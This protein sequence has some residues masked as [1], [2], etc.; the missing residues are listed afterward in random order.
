MEAAGYPWWRQRIAKLTDIFHI[1]RIDHV[2]GFYRIYS[3]P[4]Q[5]QRNAE[6]LPLSEEEAAELTGGLLPEWAPRPDDTP[7]NKAA[8]RAD[9]DARLRMAIEA[10]GS[11]AVVGEDLGSVPDYVRPH[12][13]SLDVAGFRIPHW[14]SDDEGHVIPPGDLPECS[15]VTYSTHDHDSIPALWANFHRLAADPDA[16]PDER[17]QAE[18][19]LRL[20]AEFAG[21]RE[22]IPYGPELKT[23][24]LSALLCSHSRYAAFMITDL[25]DLTDRINS[26]G[27]VG[28]HN[29]SFRLPS[30]QEAKALLELAK[31]RPILERSG[32]FSAP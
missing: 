3:F 10:A 32:R 26:P 4:W 14:D 12:L 9:G 15:F 11:S 8:N 28:P 23:A 27:T 5:P 18:E 17:E 16:D 19:Y 6:F 24:L 30:D 7:E 29:W 2:L 31:L 21:V 25:C 13:A 22:V 20:M 1:F